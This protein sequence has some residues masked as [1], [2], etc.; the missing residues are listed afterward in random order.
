MR[1]M[2]SGMSGDRRAKLARSTSRVRRSRALTP[3]TFAPAST[4]RA[5]SSPSWTSTSG[6]MPRD[7]MRST[8]DTKA[9]WVSAITI[10]RTM[11]A[12]AARASHTW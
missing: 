8:R 12:P 1:T 10:S 3:I 11:S 2:P 5:I 7:V 4:A 9:G 6:H